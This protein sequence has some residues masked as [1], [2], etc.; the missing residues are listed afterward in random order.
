MCNCNNSRVINSWN[1]MAVHSPWDVRD[2][3]ANVNLGIASG[4][5]TRSTNFL[6]S[7]WGGSSPLADTGTAQVTSNQAND[8]LTVN[9]AAQ[10]NFSHKMV[11][12]DTTLPPPLRKVLYVRGGVAW[13]NSVEIDFGGNNYVNVQLTVRDN[14]GVAGNFLDSASGSIPVASFQG[15][16]TGHQTLAFSTKGFFGRAMMCIVAKNNDT[17]VWSMFEMEWVIV[18]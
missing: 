11:N 12:V 17:G 8:F 9:N 4:Q 15:T 6:Q 5:F 1:D 14:G 16:Y 2:L 10:W 13:L 3:V 7:S 18:Q